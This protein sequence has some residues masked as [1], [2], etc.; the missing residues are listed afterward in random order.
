MPDDTPEPPESSMR[1]DPWEDAPI[2]EPDHLN[3]ERRASLHAVSD[4]EAPYDPEWEAH[5]AKLDVSENE[6]PHRPPEVV[7]SEDESERST[8][9][10]IRNV[11][12]ITDLTPPEPPSIVCRTDGL[13]LFYP[14]T[15]N[16]VHGESGDGKSWLMQAGALQE[17]QRGVHVWYLDFESRYD[18]VTQRMDD[19]GADW[20]AIRPYWHYSSPSEPLVIK[21]K[22]TR[23]G[24]DLMEG[25]DVFGPGFVVVDGVT[26]ALDLHGLNPLDN[27]DYAK[28]R[29]MLLVRSADSGAC[30]A[31]IDHVNKDP[32]TR[33]GQAMGAQHKRAGM[34]GATYDVRVSTAFARGKDGMLRLVC[35]KD[36]EGFWPKG[37]T[38][39]E[40]VATA[41]E[42]GRLTIDFREPASSKDD[43]GDFRPTGLMEKVSRYLEVE[44]DGASTRAIRR[45]VKG[46]NEYL[47]KAIKCLVAE[48]YIDPATHAVVKPYR[49]SDDPTEQEKAA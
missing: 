1:H 42:N 15:I 45:D 19:L 26:E 14:A 2:E 38:V 4:D 41:G 32:D 33:G 10:P 5:I 18:K 23:G 13:G 49:Q 36:R 3:E 9:W 31:T 20:D 40:A 24:I 12:S 43:E 21:D 16:G 37:K 6:P 17:M 48:G 47:D 39:A 25:L 44:P 7:A 8:W 28:F 29:R 35:V 11:D 27:G 22:W 46:K 30:C 34:T